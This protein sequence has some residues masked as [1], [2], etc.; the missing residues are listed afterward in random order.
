MSLDDV[1]STSAAPSTV[2]GEGRVGGNDQTREH[3]R[4][5][6]P[7]RKLKGLGRERCDRSWEHSGAGRNVEE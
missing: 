3:R 4:E 1:E 6:G 2:A 5:S 7:C